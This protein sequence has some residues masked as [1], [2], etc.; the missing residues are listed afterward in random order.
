MGPGRKSKYREFLEVL[1]DFSGL[2]LSE[3]AKACD[4]QYTNMTQYLGGSK[5]VGRRAAASALA[6]FRESWNVET[7]MEGEL[8]PESLRELPVD[9]GV[10]VLYD[11]GGNVLYLG[12]A[13]NLQ[14]E[15]RQALNRPANFAVRRGPKIALK[16]KPKYGALAERMSAYV[17]KSPKLR[18]NL[19]ALLLRAFP[20]QSHNNKMGNFR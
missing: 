2:D 19:E 5:K 20:N 11:S 10:Y 12:Q 4:M 9:P 1:K 16:T 17:V 15:V 14:T 13:K 18:H 6:H 8:I 3:F 7:F